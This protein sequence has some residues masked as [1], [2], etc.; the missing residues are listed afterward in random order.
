MIGTPEIKINLE[1]IT[2]FFL[3]FNQHQELK[4]ILRPYLLK[5][6]TTP[7]RNLRLLYS[8]ANS[9]VRSQK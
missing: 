8:G 3:R 1:T 7:A 6:I 2:A 4:Q 9:N 5:S